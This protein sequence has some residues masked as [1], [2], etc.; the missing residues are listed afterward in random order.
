MS[1]FKLNSE[2][3]VKT[4]LIRHAPSWWPS[5]LCPHLPPV[6]VCWERRRTGT[7][8][9]EG[10]WSCW[11]EPE[12]PQPTTPCPRNPESE[13]TTKLQAV[14]PA[15]SNKEE[16]VYLNVAQCNQHIEDDFRWE[17]VGVVETVA[18]RLQRLD[19]LSVVVAPV[20]ARLPQVGQKLLLC[21]SPACIKTSALPSQ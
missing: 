8:W 1:A 20:L 7:G 4:K 6:C 14:Q 5:A 21:M 10:Q 12:V 13:A 15:K 18:H 2:A 9:Q 3:L 16:V 17:D 11:E 19:K